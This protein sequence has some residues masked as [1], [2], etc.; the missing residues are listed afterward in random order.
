[1]RRYKEYL[2]GIWYDPKHVAGF[3]GP[4][5]LYE[6]VKDK[7]IS[8]LQV[9]Q[10]LQNQ[11]PYSVRRQVRRKFKKSKITVPGVNYMW[12][13][14][15][16][17]VSN[18]QKYNDGYRFLLIVIDDFSRYAFVVPVTDKKAQTI[19]DA[20]KNIFKERMP[21][22]IRSDRGKEYMNKLFQDLCKKHNIT[23][24]GSLSDHKAA[25]AESFIGKL[26]MIMYRY[27][28]SK[29]TYR[30]VE[31]LPGLIKSYN[32][33][34]HSALYGLAPSDVNEDTQHL[35]WKRMPSKAKGPKEKYK[36]KVGDK[37][38]ISYH[39]KPFRR[40]YE[41]KWTEEIFVVSHRYR[42]GNIPVYKV[43]DYDDDPL[44]GSLYGYEL[45]KVEKDE[46]SVWKIEKI[47]KK[48]K[49][50]GQTQ[51]LVRWL[52]WPTKF[53]SWI[54]EKFVPPVPTKSINTQ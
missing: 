39:K 35:I 14:D 6:A 8:K 17:D 40:G 2:E 24:I 23:H 54:D 43:V 9:Q 31:V 25:F 38:R 12:D 22:I 53:D 32:N 49:V 27:F 19:V 36:F 48:R 20:F 21:L 47:L 7:P 52:G 34:V 51:V 10:W 5:A 16:A 29:L 1:M 13:T 41:Q 46:N 45:Q 11:D 15:L 42:R 33:R 4:K 37:V 18:L 3:S 44:E 28:E 26:K 30:Y 50:K